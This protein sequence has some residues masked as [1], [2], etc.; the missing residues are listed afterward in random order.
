LEGVSLNAEGEFEIWTPGEEVASA[1]AR[2]MAS[3]DALIKWE[4]DEVKR[5]SGP[6]PQNVGE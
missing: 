6:A 3:M 1:F 5:M 2:Y 4:S